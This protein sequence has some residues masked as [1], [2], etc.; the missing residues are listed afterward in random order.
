M[1]ARGIAKESNGGRSWP[2][3]P[4][5][6]CGVEYKKMEEQQKKYANKPFEMRNGKQRRLKEEK[7][8]RKETLH[9]ASATCALFNKRQNSFWIIALEKHY[10]NDL[11]ENDICLIRWTG[12]RNDKEQSELYTCA[13]QAQGKSTIFSRSGLE[14]ESHKQKHED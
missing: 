6:L 4:R 3:T 12:H 1:Q 14:M 2:R 9:K 8:D 13:L 11:E 5:P 10:Y 7:I